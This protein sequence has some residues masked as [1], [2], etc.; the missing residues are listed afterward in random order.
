VLSGNLKSLTHTHTHTPGPFSG[1]TQVSRYQKGKTNL[2]FVKQ[3]IVS[4]TGI[5]RAICKSAS[6]WGQIAMPAPHH[7]S[8]YR[9]D[10]LHAAQPTA[11]KHWSLKSLNELQLC[12]CNTEP[13]PPIDDVIRA[14]I[15][16]RFVQLL[17]NDANCTLQVRLVLILQVFDWNS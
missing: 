12:G 15:V 17:Q 4:G 8:F 1:T 14:G 10:A 13:N 11:S 2:D 9:P 7:S 16:P 5:S 3:E 6:C